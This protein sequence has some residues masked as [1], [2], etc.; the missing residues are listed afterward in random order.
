MMKNM[1]TDKK[2]AATSAAAK[3]DAHSPILDDLR[4][5]VPVAGELR[6]AQAVAE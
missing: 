5:A 3:A 6:I 2:T 4:R 1:M